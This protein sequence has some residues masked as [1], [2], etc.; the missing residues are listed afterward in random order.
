M[1][2]TGRIIRFL[3]DQAGLAY[4]EFAFALPLLLMLFLGGVEVT[5]YILIVQKTEKIAA[6]V[7]DLTAQSQTTTSSELSIIIQAA[8][9]VMQPFSFGSN[10]YVIISSVTKTGTNAPVV[11]WQYSGGGTW[12]QTSQVGTTGHTASLPSGFTMVDK[13]NII[14]AEVYYNYAPMLS[15]RNNVMGSS[16]IYKTAI[17]KPRL[18]DLSVLGFVMPLAV[19]GALL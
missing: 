13:D 14:I 1:E 2:L 15:I 7:A 12:T 16:R 4:L 17:F 10:G 9:Q 19:K 6:T 11:N 18:G 5:R 8:S 3:R